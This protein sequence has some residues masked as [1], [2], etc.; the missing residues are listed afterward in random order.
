[1]DTSLLI[2]IFGFMLILL[3][4]QIGEKKLICG[5]FS[6]KTA[7][8]IL[9]SFPV[10]SFIQAFISKYIEAENSFEVHT[11]DFLILVFVCTCISGLFGI[12]LK[13][14]FLIIP[15]SIAIMLIIVA[16]LA[17]CILNIVF[18]FDFNKGQFR[19]HSASVEFRYAVIIE[20][21]SLSTFFIISTFL[22]Q[23]GDEQPSVSKPTSK[24]K[25]S[26]E[27]PTINV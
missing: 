16:S 13:K 8:I 1:M 4:Y 27:A 18:Y 11:N 25:P 2:F 14:E 10:L 23:F 22:T 26:S 6:C 17:S 5:V 9:I 19:S 15:F 3:V 7:S 21:V 24:S 20:L 12:E